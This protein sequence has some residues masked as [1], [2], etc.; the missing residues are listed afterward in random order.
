VDI[1]CTTTWLIEA[2][3]IRP[4][5]A[6]IFPSESTNESLTYMGR[7]RESTMLAPSGGLGSCDHAQPRMLSIEHIHYRILIVLS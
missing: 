5:T 4:V 1:S 7:P 3:T 2:G 6:R